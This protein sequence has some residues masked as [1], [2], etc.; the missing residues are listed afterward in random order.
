MLGSPSEGSV[1]FRHLEAAITVMKQLLDKQALD[2]AIATLES[3]CSQ[4]AGA[5]RRLPWAPSRSAAGVAGVLT[6]VDD[7]DLSGAGAGLAGAWLQKLHRLQAAAGQQR[8]ADGSSAA[9]VQV[10]T[11]CLRA[12][13]VR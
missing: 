12:H 9:V 3:E 11:A 10:R 1:E 4:L 7:M 13:C 2:I 8:A 5:A 6:N